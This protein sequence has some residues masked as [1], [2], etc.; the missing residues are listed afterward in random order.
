MNLKN[1]ANYIILIIS[2]FLCAIV[3][4]KIWLLLL[5][6]SWVPFYYLVFN[7]KTNSFFTLF[8]TG[9]IFG[10]FYGLSLFWWSVDSITNYANSFSLGI[11]FLLLMAFIYAILYGGLAYV[12]HYI[13]IKTKTNGNSIIN[14]M[15]IV[16]IAVL[17]DTML[18]FLFAGIPFLNVRLGYIVSI[19]NN[20]LQWSQFFGIQYLTF[21]IVLPNVF[22][23][24]FI[25]SKKR[26]FLIIPVC[27]LL[28]SYSLGYFL[29]DK[30]YQEEVKTIGVSVVSGNIE[31]KIAWNSSNGDILANN[32]FN[33]CKKE[34]K[35]KP[36]VVLFPESTIP[37][38]YQNDDDLITEIEKIN[39]NAIH[40]IGANIASENNSNA[41][42]NS[43]IFTS[44]NKT[45]ND[46]YYKNVSLE[47]FEK[48]IF[49]W[50]QIP[51][52]QQKNLYYSNKGNLK[53]IT[54]KFGKS[55]VLICNE[56][57]EYGLIKSQVENG[58]NF[59]LVLN[60]DAWFKDTY[61]S[62]IHFYLARIA[63]VMFHRNFA[64]SSNGGINGFIDYNGR[65][66]DTAQTN[67]PI[68]LHE[69]IKLSN[70]NTFFFK[71]P[72]LFSLLVFATLL[73]TLLLTIKY[74]SN[75]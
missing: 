41:I 20:L 50:Y 23:A 37:W 59:F 55:G 33:L 28:V 67:Q 68:S 69:K 8:K 2:A 32:Y 44:E 53:P 46:A 22:F 66:L 24:Y 16:F 58:A 14:L 5:F 6:F 40:V 74:Y 36:D 1:S 12:L 31:P 18:S 54:T 42:Y 3:Y 29:V 60:N 17:F 72:F 13:F 70:D 56:L 21:I 63:A 65:L 47:A 9:S 75:D 25:K 38:L 51:F 48:P 30:N 26:R 62:D 39:P 71:Y 19:N 49:N 10:F 11:V 27:F 45:I 57:A 34:V 43:A 73:T 4:K 15:S 7:S 64:V 35:N 52:N 61:I